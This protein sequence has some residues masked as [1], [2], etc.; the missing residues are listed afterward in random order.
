MD[1]EL[2]SRARI[3]DIEREM[4]RIRL[5]AAVSAESERRPAASADRRGAVPA[6]PLRRLRALRLAA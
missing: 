1:A 3:R 5:A 2:L 6:M 4:S